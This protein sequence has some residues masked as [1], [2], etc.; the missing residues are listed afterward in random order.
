MM[1]KPARR[2]RYLL[3]F[4][5]AGLLACSAAENVEKLM[6]SAETAKKEGQLHLA[7]DLYHRAAG[8]RPH[9]F[10]IQYGTGLLYL[11]VKGRE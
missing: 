5:L 3:L 11:Q 9:D 2:Q 8:L 6:T 7:A 4:V 1:R 10:Q